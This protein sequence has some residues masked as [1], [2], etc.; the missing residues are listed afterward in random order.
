MYLG[1]PSMALILLLLCRG[2]AAPDSARLQERGIEERGTM[3]ICILGH[4]TNRSLAS[5]ISRDMQQ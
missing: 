5:G 4:P 2:F 1:H 3:P